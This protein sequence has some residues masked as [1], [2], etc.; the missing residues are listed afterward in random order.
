M[1]LGFSGKILT[2]DLNS[3]DITEEQL[4]EKMYRDFLGGAGL[5]VK[6]LLE[7]QREGVDP[8]GPDNLLGFMP[9][10]FGGT[11]VP[12]GSRLT[13]VSKSPLTG[14]W[15]DASVG[16]HV[17]YELKRAGYD[18][19]LVRGVSKDPVYLLI[20]QGKAE[21]RDASSL[22]GLGTAETVDRINTEVGG[23]KLRTLCVGP[24]GE[25]RSLIA[26]IIAE[27][28]RAAARSGLGA[29]MGAKRLKAIAV[30]GGHAV[31]VADASRIKELRK[32]FIKAIQEP[33]RFFIKAIM[34]IGTGGNADALIKIGAA[35]IK[36][37]NLIGA[38]SLPP[39]TAYGPAMNEYRVGKDTCAKC[40]I[41][42]RGKL[43]IDGQAYPRPEYE[44][45]TSFG[46]MCFNTDTRA[47]IEANR[48]CNDY[49]L[50]TIS[51]GTVI[52]FAME[53]YEQG[54]ITKEDTHGLELTW[55]DSSAMLVL[56]E[57][58]AKR[59]GV[60][61]L[62]ADGV[63]KAVEK[64]G[65]ATEKCAIHVGGQEPGYHDPRL[66]PARGTGYICDP[67]P[68]RHTAVAGMVMAEAGQT[69]GPYPEFK[70]PEAELHDYTKKSAVYKNPGKYEHVFAAT[71]LC[72]FALMSGAFRLFGQIVA[73]TGWEITPE[74][75]LRV[76]E[77]IQTMRQLFNIREGVVPR[78]IQLP[79]RLSRPAT[80]GPF[81]DIAVDFEILRKQYYEAMGWNV[82]TGYPKK[83]RLKELGLE[84]YSG[85][86]KA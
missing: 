5:G 57:K 36:N 11:S 75:M 62:F 26:S 45:V 84:E 86:V 46:P 29:V 70:S 32:G 56:L 80:V 63:K 67:T 44:T 72:K 50:D 9:G 18:G 23:G 76:G 59:E 47:I 54:F 15:G 79:A 82:E 8:F 10:I 58:I 6:L 66:F 51:T 30:R 35:P 77:R 65:P 40:P 25:S 22:R 19:I 20:D 14:G 37:W 7:R 38:E 12:S 64:I 68:G 60:G 85:I 31:D 73:V 27:K 34:S 53:C 13:V 74:E 21:L 83:S 17:A 28:E 24:A 49:G 43:E 55:G 42:C 71:G 61:A 81:K 16:G 69:L 41:A 1:G 2:V 39:E 4:A 33:N 78:Q 3:A 48:L 52:A